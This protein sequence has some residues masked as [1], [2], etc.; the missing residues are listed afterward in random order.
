MN[1]PTLSEQVST[2]QLYQEFY[3]ISKNK[4]KGIIA[5]K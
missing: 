3:K 1:H 2:I 4:E 5:V